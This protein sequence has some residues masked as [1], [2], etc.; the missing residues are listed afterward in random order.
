MFRSTAHVS[1][2]QDLR[3]HSGPAALGA[4]AQEEETTLADP[5]FSVLAMSMQLWLSRN[6]LTS[7]QDGFFEMYVESEFFECSHPRSA[8]RLDQ[9]GPVMV[10]F[11]H[12]VMAQDGTALGKSAGVC[13][14]SFPFGTWPSLGLPKSSK[15]FRR[16]TLR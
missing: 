5:S 8:K 15:I 7:L 1:S 16:A 6:P 4:L 11:R 14:F 10:S 12:F 13:C 3:N 2:D 9:H